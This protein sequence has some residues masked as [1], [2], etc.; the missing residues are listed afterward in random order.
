MESR[1]CN[2]KKAQPFG[3]AFSRIVRE[4]TGIQPRVRERIMKVSLV[5]SATRHHRY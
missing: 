3:W 2:A 1:P 5:Y 4:I